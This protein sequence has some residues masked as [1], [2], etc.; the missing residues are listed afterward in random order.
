MDAADIVAC[1][2]APVP[3][4]ESNSANKFFD[5]LAAGKAVA[6]NYGGWQAEL[7]RDAGA[8]LVLDRDPRRAARQ[9]EHWSADPS[10]RVTA[11]VQARNLAESRFSR[12]DHARQ[13][14]AV[15][16]EQHEIAIGRTKP[17]LKGLD[18]Q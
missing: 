4:L 18:A 9:L 14:L 16:T 7:L 5:G 2:F 10:L 6:I 15:L 13:L 1:V 8:G 17:R 11:G 3:E 12:D